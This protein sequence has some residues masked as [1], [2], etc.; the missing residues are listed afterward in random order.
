MEV[1]AG[2][3]ARTSQLSS[4]GCNCCSLRPRAQ[5]EKRFGGKAPGEGQ[6]GFGLEVLSFKASGTSD[7]QSQHETGPTRMKS[8]CGRKR[9]HESILALC[10]VKHTAV[11]E[12][13]GKTEGHEGQR[14]L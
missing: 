13:H 7:G 14:G 10:L 6:L 5:G 11:R 12:C 4:L 3:W 2:R 8:V 9:F 1:R